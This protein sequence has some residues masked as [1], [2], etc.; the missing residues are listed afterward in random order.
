MFGLES[1]FKRITLQRGWEKLGENLTLGIRDVKA[2]GEV[3]DRINQHLETLDGRPPLREEKAF[4][5][6]EPKEGLRLAIPIATAHRPD[7]IQA[8]RNDSELKGM[9]RK[10]VEL[11]TKGR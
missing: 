7:L 3:C 6:L 9:L 5:A 8:I 4:P 11:A 10:C 1:T 2:A